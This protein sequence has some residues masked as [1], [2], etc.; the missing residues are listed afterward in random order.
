MLIC[1]ICTD[2]K[3]PDRRDGSDW[4]KLQHHYFMAHK[5][6]AY[7]ARIKAEQ[8]LRSLKIENWTKLNA[9]TPLHR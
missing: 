4:R 9:N 6:S 3:F 1:E 2:R 7:D 5:L 8:Q